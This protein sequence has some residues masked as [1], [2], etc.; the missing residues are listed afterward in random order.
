M[1]ADQLTTT[2]LK[3]T[4]MEPVS[5]NLNIGQYERFVGLRVRDRDAAR[6]SVRS[7]LLAVLAG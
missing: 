6:E 1:G 7:A 5:K 3:A 2:I 4:Y